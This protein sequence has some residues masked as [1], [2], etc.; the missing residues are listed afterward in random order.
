MADCN[1]EWESGEEGATCEGGLF[2]TSLPGSAAKRLTH[3]AGPNSSS[4]LAVRFSFKSKL[5]TYRQGNVL[6]G[7]AQPLLKKSWRE[8]RPRLFAPAATPADRVLAVV[9]PA[10]EEISR[11]VDNFRGCHAY[12][13]P[14][15]AKKRIRCCPVKINREQECIFRPYALPQQSAYHARQDVS[16][17]RA[18][19]PRVAARIDEAA[20][21]WRSANAAC[22]FQNRDAV[23]CPRQPGCRCHTIF[24]NRTCIAREQTRRFSWM[25]GQYRRRPA[26]GQRSR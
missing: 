6:C 25:R 12:R 19:Q 16:R 5:V 17:A 18:A 24:L 10:V 1:E 22:A 9:Y 26:S 8:S 7:I 20:L 14:E 21:V 2:Q 23:E 4:F 13:S 11:R 15:T 3:L